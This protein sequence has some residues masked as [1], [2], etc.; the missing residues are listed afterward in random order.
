MWNIHAWNITHNQ[1][2]QITNTGSD[3]DKSLKH[4]E[5][6]NLVDTE[7][8]ILDGSTYNEVQEQIVH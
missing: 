6:K 3:M 2:E 8:C 7:E 4:C 5:F 1:K